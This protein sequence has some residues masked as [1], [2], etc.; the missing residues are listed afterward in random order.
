MTKDSFTPIAWF[1]AGFALFFFTRTVT[2]V[3]LAII[4]AP[5][6][7]LRFIRTQKLVK[8]ILLTLLGFTMSLTI[9]LWGLFSFE[10]SAFSLL[11]NTIR[12]L[13]IAIILS[14]PYIADRLIVRRINGFVST[15][16]FP[17]SCTMF[18]FLDSSFGPIDG[19]GIFYAY[20]QYGNL[21]LM[22]MLSVFGIWGEVF[23][24]SW[25][26]SVVNWVWDHGFEPN[27]VKKGLA[28]FL[29]IA[30][31]VLIYGG[32]RVSPFF[33]PRGDTVRVAAITFLPDP[34]KAEASIE[35]V[36]KGRLYS[37]FEKNRFNDRAA[38]ETSG[39]RGSEDCR[40]AGIRHVDR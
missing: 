37:P 22:Q 3:P 17:V 39:V 38:H 14:F 7:I 18:Y 26:A 25:I 12:S 4:I 36:L 31:L 32:V 9:S 11:F 2:F 30:G 15:L 35:K 1:F 24:L 13:L 5:I 19:L 34:Q 16:I 27:R 21:T 33:Y 40:V 10:D 20:N 29:C 28:V 23:L 8:G 6:F